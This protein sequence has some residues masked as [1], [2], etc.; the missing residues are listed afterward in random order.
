MVLR[1]VYSLIKIPS[2]NHDSSGQNN[3]IQSHLTHSQIVCCS[4]ATLFFLSEQGVCDNDIEMTETEASAI[5]CCCLILSTLI[6]SSISPITNQKQL[7]A[8]SNSVINGFTSKSAMKAMTSMLLYTS[9]NSSPSKKLPF[10]ASQSIMSNLGCYSDVGAFDGILSLF[11]VCMTAQHSTKNYFLRG[12]AL[13]RIGGLIVQQLQIGANGEISPE[14]TNHA[15]RFI[16]SILSISSATASASTSQP[17]SPCESFLSPTVYRDSNEYQISVA[18]ILTFANQEGLGGLLALISLPQHLELCTNYSKNNGNANGRSEVSSRGHVVEDI[19]ENVGQILKS[20]MTAISL[21][22][23]LP[24]STALQ[25]A[26]SSAISAQDSQK[27]LE[28][29]YRTQLIRS[30]L[31]ALT[32]YGAKGHMTGRTAATLVHVLSELVLTSSKF[33]AQFVEYN[34]LEVIV[35][36]SISS[37]A[38]SNSSGGGSGG[39]RDMKDSRERERAEDRDAEEHISVCTLQISSHLARHSEKYFDTLQAVFTPSRLISLLSQVTVCPPHPNCS[40]I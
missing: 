34:G 29:V 16:S 23:L 30:L 2:I 39:K 9:N 3:T 18:A 21:P 26:A 8:I 1:I 28:G 38:E 27:V 36:I 15:L 19:L 12:T 32:T 11:N 25:S 10:T 37:A 7:S 31:L 35:E 4:Q 22:S 14:G 13:L 24:P 17:L 40:E 6:S 33:M 20:I 5:L